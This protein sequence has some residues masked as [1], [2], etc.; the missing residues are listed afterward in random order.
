M[1]ERIL[2]GARGI[3]KA[4][5]YRMARRDAEILALCCEEAKNGFLA[6]SGMKA[7][8]EE[9][10]KG[11]AAGAAGEFLAIKKSLCRLDGFVPDLGAVKS[12][13]EGD[14]SVTFRDEA[15]PL[16]EVIRF[17]KGMNKPGRYGRLSW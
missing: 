4:L 11:V 13:S 14:T 16:D 7:L 17:L 5:G 12:V 15:A 8:P 6:A 3:L 10:V 1:S 9:R 2:K